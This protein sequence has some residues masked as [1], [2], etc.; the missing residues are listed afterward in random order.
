MRFVQKHME[1]EF[2]DVHISLLCM[3]AGEISTF[4]IAE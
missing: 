3:C 1:D 2:K 4:S